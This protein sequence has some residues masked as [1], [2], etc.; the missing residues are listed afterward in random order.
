ME[1]LIKFFAVIGLIETVL[2]VAIF[3]WL[4]FLYNNKDGNTP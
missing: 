4:Y 3:A 2:G 1:I